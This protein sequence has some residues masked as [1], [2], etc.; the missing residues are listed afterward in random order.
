MMSKGITI[1]EHTGVFNGNIQQ[2]RQQS[3]DLK[4]WVKYKFFF[5][6]HIASREERYQ[7][8]EKGGKPR[9]YKISTVNHIPL[10]KS[11]MR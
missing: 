3:A 11:T 1:L 10:K 8:E 7:T 9:Q 6:K 2:W 5:T 4:T